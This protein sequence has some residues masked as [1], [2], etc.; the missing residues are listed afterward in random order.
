MFE[1]LSRENVGQYV[2][3]EIGRPKWRDARVK[4]VECD[5]QCAILKDVHDRHPLFRFTFGRRLI[6]REF[7][8]Y[9]VLEGVEGVPRAYRKLDK[10]AFLVEYINGE[11]VSRKKVRAGLEVGEEFYAGCFGIIEELHRR[12]VVHLD[13]RSNKNFLIGAGDRPY[14]VDFASAICVPRWLPLRGLWVRLLGASDRAGVLKMKQRL[15][16][17]LVS[18]GQRKELARFERLRAVLVP[19][20]VIFRAI[21]RA[22]R[23]RRRAKAAR[24]R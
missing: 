4:V 15:T 18:D 3:R 14:V 20:L 1:E 21:R 9:Q 17:G 22:A 10:D 16:P 5:G 19:P 8:V 2:V 24:G 23:N 7:R 6:A 13:L 12:G 11:F